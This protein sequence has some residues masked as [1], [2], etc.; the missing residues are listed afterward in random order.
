MINTVSRRSLAVVVALSA[1]AMSLQAQQPTTPPVPPAI[2]PPG[3]PPSSGVPGQPAPVTTLPAGTAPSGQCDLLVTP[4]SDSTH[5]TS[6]KL[7]SGE[8]NNFVGGGITGHCPVQQITLIADSAEWFGDLHMWHLIG[9]VHYVEPRLTMDSDVA[10]YYLTDEHLLSE[11]NVHTLL[12]SGTTLVGPRVE[13]YRAAPKIRAVAHMIAP[14]RPTIN[15]VEK[16]STGKPSPPTIVVANTVVMDGDSLVYA[17]QN[18]VITRPDVVATGDTAMMNS[19]TEFARLMKS[20]KIVSRGKKQFILYGEVI[21]LFG[22]NHALQR[23]LSKGKAKSISDSATMTADTIDF[24]MEAG[25][26]QRAYAWGKSRAHAVNPTYDVL[27]DSIDLRMPGQ[28]TREIRAVRKAYAQSLPDTAKLHTKEKDW[29][30]GDTITA[31]F[32]S[33]QAPGDTSS[34]PQMKQ[35]IAQGSAQ[36]FYQLAAKDSGVVGPAINYVKGRDISIFFANRVVQVVDIVDQAQ[37]V[38]LEPQV[39][40]RSDTLTTRRG[41]GTATTRRPSRRP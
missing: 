21:D 7:P 35:L 39:P 36:S 33:T 17:S 38:Y 20:P 18:V 3:A 25:L 34:Q 30:R 10:T 16:D 26:M 28:R 8:Y 11:G 41:A 23:V 14:G 27:S 9:H 5:F 2:P 19:Q 13:Y 40:G 24:R 32:D 22:Q 12:P 15:V 4:N 37:G 29:M 31:H 1:F 6:A